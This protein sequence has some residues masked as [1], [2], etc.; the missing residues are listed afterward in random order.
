TDVREKSIWP[1]GVFV[2][3]RTTRLDDPYSET[4]ERPCR[5]KQIRHANSAGAGPTPPPDRNRS[6]A[7]S[8]HLLLRGRTRRHG[9]ERYPRHFCRHW[10]LLPRTL[11]RLMPDAKLPDQ[12]AR[13]Q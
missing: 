1:P 7:T 8:Q 2:E 6:S 5:R 12:T 13:R 10:P 9:P 11:P 3:L 4:L